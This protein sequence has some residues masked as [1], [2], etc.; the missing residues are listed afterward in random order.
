MHDLVIKDDALVVGTHG[1]S[2]WILD[3]LTPVR[4]ATKD[5]AGKPLHLYPVAD[6]TAWRYAYTPRRT[7]SGQNPPRGALISYWLKDKVE[8]EVVMEISDA[9]GALVR[10]MS[11]LKRPAEGVDDDPKTDEN[12]KPELT[13]AAGT[14]RAVWDL[15]WGGATVIKK[16]KIDMGHPDPGPRALPGTYTVKL[17]SGTQTATAS[18]KVLPDPRV[19]ASGADLEAQRELAQ[20]I[21]GDV[22][23]VS[24]M[25]TE[26]Q[27]V[28]A[29]VAARQ[30]AFAAHADATSLSG[31][32]AALVKKLDA[33]EARL[34]NPTAEVTYDILAMK[35]GAQL[36]SRLVPLFEAVAEGDGAPTR[37][38]RQVYETLSAE[39]QHSERVSRHAGHGRGGAQRAGRQ[40]VDGVRHG[41]VGRGRARRRRNRRR[42]RPA[43]FT[44]AARTCSPNTGPSAGRSFGTAAGW[45]RWSASSGSR[46]T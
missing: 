45:C 8:G 33:L 42:A 19:G 24:A 23:R 34:H 30:P 17:V 40:A 9:S 26:V 16:A 27:S 18:V 21:L 12:R 32:S 5:I 41:E 31:A 7:E 2:L 6:T 13:T 4:Q 1:R 38:Q 22:S 3:D 15:R 35:G 44:A 29:Q 43:R 28:Q 37:G 11:S 20:R 36:Y 14:N 10:R 39:L 25:V 46:L